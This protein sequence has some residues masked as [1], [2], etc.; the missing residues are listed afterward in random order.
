M[1]ADFNLHGLEKTGTSKRQPVTRSNFIVDT[2]H[3]DFI[4]DT[5]KRINETP[6]GELE[7]RLPEFIQRR[8]QNAF[9]LGGVLER[10]RREKFW[11]P[12]SKQAKNALFERWVED[13]FDYSGR[14][15]RYLISVYLGLARAAI[16]ASKVSEL[17]WSKLRMIAPLLRAANGN[18]QADDSRAYNEEL[19]RLARRK[20]RRALEA[21]LRSEFANGESSSKQHAP[22]HEPR[23]Y[24]FRIQDDAAE[25]VDAALETI[26]KETGHSGG[27]AL[28]DLAKTIEVRDEVPLLELV[29]KKAG[30]DTSLATYVKLFG[31]PGG[32]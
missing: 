24:V 14:K 2:V 6:L 5:V 17:G 11:N 18:D 32:G 28:V 22:K 26:A 25:V 27:A 20:S 10:I 21:V 29:M 15:A 13:T 7:A 31:Q 23:R 1:I 9:V 19:L 16:P 30:K 8:S 4:R 12:G 3:S